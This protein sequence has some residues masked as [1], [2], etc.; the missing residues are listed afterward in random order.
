MFVERRSDGPVS[1]VYVEQQ[2]PGQ[3][4]LPASDEALQSFLADQP[5]LGRDSKGR[6]CLLPAPRP[7]PLPVKRVCKMSPP[8]RR[9]QVINAAPAKADRPGHEQKTDR[10]AHDRTARNALLGHDLAMRFITAVYE[11]AQFES[12]PWRYIGDTAEWAGIRRL[13]EFELAL[14]RAISENLLIVE[15]G[16]S[17]KLTFAGARTALR[18]LTRTGNATKPAAL[19][20][21][22]SPMT[23]GPRHDSPQSP[24]T[25]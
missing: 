18:L 5:R 16:R 19:A 9:H 10:P 3:A 11:H 21:S 8:Q 15:D 6:T 2:Y 4:W 12:L 7:K 1:A 22:T 14:E 24:A 25:I 20:H 23:S 13:S 17:V